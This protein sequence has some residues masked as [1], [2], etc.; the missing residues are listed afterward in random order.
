MEST[1]IG[2]CVM[3]KSPAI[4]AFS[5]IQLNYDSDLFDI[6]IRII[7]NDIHKSMD[8]LSLFVV[9]LFTPNSSETAQKTERLSK[10]YFFRTTSTYTAAE[11][12]MGPFSPPELIAY[13]Q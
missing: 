8:V 5:I 4:F 9:Y 13:Y 10:T 12:L 1:H 2:V 7:G 6:R 3:G 11:V